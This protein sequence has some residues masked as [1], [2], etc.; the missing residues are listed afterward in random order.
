MKR[1]VFL[2]LV[3][4]FVLGC[5]PNI[6]KK[7]V[8]IGD[9]STNMI[10]VKSEG[11]NFPYGAENRQETLEQDFWLG[12]TE[13]P[14]YLWRQVYVWATLGTDGSK[15]AGAYTIANK[16]RAGSNDSTNDHPVSAISWRDAVIWC[17]AYTE[18]F[19][20]K[21][22]TDLTCVYYT[23]EEYTEPI[24]VS[25]ENPPQES[26]R[27]GIEDRPYVKADATGFRLPTNLEWE[28]AARWRNDSMNSVSG[29]SNP[30]FTDANFYSGISIQYLED[31]DSDLLWENQR[32]HVW[33]TKKGTAP[34]KSVKP[35]HHGFYDMS[36][37]V[38]EW[39]Y[40]DLWIRKK[41]LAGGHY[42]EVFFEIGNEK[43][44][45]PSLAFSYMGFRVAQNQ[46]KS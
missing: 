3:L 13:V 7:E 15:G 41:R 45:W 9:I 44:S 8:S 16:G 22:G 19:N 36:G 42:D 29:F 37:N 31:M 28:F 4:F 21:N 2:L 30:F 32:S 20:S 35:N 18:W 46:I 40:D 39:C 33:F 27:Y 1:M 11:V 17:N 23:D 24:R 43:T 6:Q 14:Y 5:A 12:E 26:N 25:T 34:I 10:L 38:S